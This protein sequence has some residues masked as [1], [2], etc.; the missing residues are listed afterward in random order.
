M[1][2]PLHLPY[3]HT[4]LTWST[5]SRRVLSELEHLRELPDSP[6]PNLECLACLHFSS[7]FDWLYLPVL[8]RNERRSIEAN[9]EKE[10]ELRL[11]ELKNQICWEREYG[12]VNGRRK[13]TAVRDPEHLLWRTV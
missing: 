3:L 8:S 4:I 5:P 2:A 13:V 1:L 6:L 12:E 10:E 7:T 11:V 9:T